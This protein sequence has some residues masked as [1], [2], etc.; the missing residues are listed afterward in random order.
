MA[1]GIASCTILLHFLHFDA[2]LVP[3][4][5][6]GGNSHVRGCS[7]PQAGITA[8]KISSFINL[9]QKGNLFSWVILNE[10]EQHLGYL[11]PISSLSRRQYAL[12]FPRYS[13][14]FRQ[15]MQ[16][17]NQSLPLTTGCTEGVTLSGISGPL[18]LTPWNNKRWRLFNLH[19]S[20]QN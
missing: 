20:L 8:D 9:R 10:T 11:Q 18:F 5:S 6:R 15:V 14:L 3:D 4:Y 2:T 19:K 16:M 17:N 12:L 1:F 13:L 7:N